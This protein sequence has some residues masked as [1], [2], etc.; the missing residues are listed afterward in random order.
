MATYNASV[1]KAQK[2]EQQ[3]L[4][5]HGEHCSADPEKLATVGREPGHQVRIKRNDSEYGLYT[6]SK[7]AERQENPDNIVRM[8]EDGR[9]RLGT[10]GEFAGTLDSQVPHPTFTDAEAEAHNEFVERLVDNGRHTG[11]I[12]IAPHGGAIEP[13]TDEQAERV[14]SQ[15]ADRGVSSW[16]CRGWKDPPRDDLDRP[17]AFKRWHIRSTD[18]HEASFPLLRKVIFRCFG[19]AVAFHGYAPE[20]GQPDV[21]VGGTSPLREEIVLA[22]RDAVAG[23]DITVELP[24]PIRDKDFNGDSLLN[25]VNRLTVDK[26][27]GV[28]IEQSLRARSRHG[29]AIADAVANVYSPKIPQEPPGTIEPKT[30]R[31]AILEQYVVLKATLSGPKERIDLSNEQITLDDGSQTTII[32]NDPD[33]STTTNFPTNPPNFFAP[34]PPIVEWEI[35]APQPPIPKALPGTTQPCRSEG[36]SLFEDPGVGRSPLGRPERTP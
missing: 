11:L 29:K 13:H 22:I 17:A 21:L 2:L 16:L 30:P 8:G 9:E 31:D 27:G 12:A 35:P 18:I 3:D 19:H 24:D 15:L 33:G 4:I 6:V 25:I 7:E 20:P 34:F 10:S 23:S 36:C 26:A 5:D 14:A 32:V 28:Q 1:E